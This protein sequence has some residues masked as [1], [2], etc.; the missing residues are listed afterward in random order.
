MQSQK[1]ETRDWSRRLEDIL[2]LPTLSTQV[3]VNDRAASPLGFVDLSHAIACFPTGR[4]RRRSRLLSL[5][6]YIC[7]EIRLVG[8]SLEEAAALAWRQFDIR[9]IGIAHIDGKK[10]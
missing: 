8:K 10:R 3:E 9:A 1:S 4:G 7:E 5:K 6:D 2:Q